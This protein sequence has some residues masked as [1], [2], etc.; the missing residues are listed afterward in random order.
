MK[1]YECEV[2]GYV[3]DPAEG[4]PNAGVDPGTAFEDL[5][6]GWVCPLCQE[7][8]EVFN[9]IQIIIQQIE[10]GS[11]ADVEDPISYIQWL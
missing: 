4:D 6:E 5:P 7:G 1:K 9:E 2:C 10:I 11:S 8:V 3:Y